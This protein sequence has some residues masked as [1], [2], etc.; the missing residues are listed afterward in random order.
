[1][2]NGNEEQPHRHAREH[3]V[4]RSQDEE[5]LRGGHLIPDKASA[6]YKGARHNWVCPH[7]VR[8]ARGGLYRQV[9]KRGARKA[10]LVLPVLTPQLPLPPLS[11]PGAWYGTKWVQYCERARHLPAARAQEFCSQ[12]VFRPQRLSRIH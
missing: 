11:G 3:Q 1:M 8:W 9:R 5:G 10:L 2:V 7:W 4:W 6:K 12:K